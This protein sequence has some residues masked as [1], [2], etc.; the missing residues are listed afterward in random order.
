[1]RVC[2]VCGN[3]FESGGYVCPYCASTLEGE[4][5]R[6]GPRVFVHRTVNLESG[7]PQ[8]EQALLHLQTALEEARRLGVRVLTIIHGYGSSGRGGAIRDESRKLLDHL[9]SRGE[10]QRVIAGEEFHRRNGQ[11]KDLLRR[12]PQLAAN[13]NLNRAN[14]GVTLAI[15]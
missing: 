3:E 7:K 15:L 12:Y 1:M 14:R 6:S 10:L 5:K 11:V 9:C 8:V 2:T 4:E 13:T